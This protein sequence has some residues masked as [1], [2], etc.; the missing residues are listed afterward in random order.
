MPL[1]NVFTSSN[2]ESGSKYSLKQ[3]KQQNHKDQQPRSLLVLLLGSCYVTGPC[4]KHVFR[5][6]P[7]SMN[8]LKMMRNELQAFR[9]GSLH[10]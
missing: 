9:D 1:T 2:C 10:V 5:C 4:T 6:F 8:S 3:P 7:R